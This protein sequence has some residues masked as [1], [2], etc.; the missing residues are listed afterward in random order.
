[1]TENEILGVSQIFIVGHP[2]MFPACSRA[3]ARPLRLSLACATLSL[4]LL[5]VR[6]VSRFWRGRRSVN[7]G[8]RE[9]CI[10]YSLERRNAFSR[11]IL[12]SGSL[13]GPLVF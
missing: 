6:Y 13:R 2:G 7:W 12:P 5:R 3:S 10:F 11:E 8:A 1:M 9:R 4:R